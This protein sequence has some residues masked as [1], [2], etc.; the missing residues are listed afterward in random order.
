MGKPRAGKT[1][2]AAIAKSTKTKALE[3][4]ASL[5]V[6][7][8]NIKENDPETIEVTIGNKE[9]VLN[10]LIN[11]GIESGELLAYPDGKGMKVFDPRS[12][13][14]RPGWVRFID[15]Y[16]KYEFNATEAYMEAYPK[17]TNRKTAGT[18]ACKL[19]KVPRIIEEIRYRLDA[20]RCTDNY[21]V[22]RLMEQSTFVDSFRIN[23]AVAAT[24]TLAKVRGLLQDTRKPAFS[25]E[26]PAV[27]AAPF[28]K[29]EMEK[30]QEQRA[31]I[32]RII[33]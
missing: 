19:L 7:E 26:N 9:E 31:K 16:F 14:L 20:E 13:G 17:N 23:A 28:T 2:N 11:V 24:A 1:H 15:A 32:G 18:E 5:S 12:E 3:A 25:N 30:M 29:E 21:V 33:E 4:E 6:P 10:A 8:K 22:S 27:F